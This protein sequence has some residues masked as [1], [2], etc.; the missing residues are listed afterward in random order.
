MLRQV[1]SRLVVAVSRSILPLRAASLRTRS[2]VPRVTSL[3]A[4]QFIRPFQTSVARFDVAP[5]PSMPDRNSLEEKA[6]VL[7]RKLDVNAPPEQYFD[8]LDELAS[9][10]DQLGDHARAASYVEK[11]L[12]VQK[13]KL[14]ET[15]IEVGDTCNK[16]ARLYRSMNE[17]QLA[18]PLQE[19]AVE[20]YVKHQGEGD[21][22]TLGT[23]I[24]LSETYAQAG[25][26]AGCLS[27]LNAA[28][29]GQRKVHGNQHMHL[30][31]LLD[32][33]GSITASI[34][35][36]AACTKAY[37]EA[38][39]ILHA[40]EGVQSLSAAG[41][42][43]NFGLAMTQSGDTKRGRELLDKALEVHKSAK[44]EGVHLAA[45]LSDAGMAL[46]HANDHQGALQRFKDALR[47]CRAHTPAQS[48]EIAQTA[49]LLGLQHLML[50]QFKEAA[51]L[52]SES[53]DIQRKLLGSRHGAVANTLVSLAGVYRSQK[54]LADA[55]PL[56]EEAVSIK[57]ELGDDPHLGV[58]LRVLSQAL[59]AEKQFD[60]ALSTIKEAEAVELKRVGPDS[61]NMSVVYSNM[62]AIYAATENWQE[63]LN[64]Y[65]K[66]EAIQRKAD[67]PMLIQTLSDVAGVYVWKQMHHEAL[68]YLEEALQRC[69]KA[70]VPNKDESLAQLMYNTAAVLTK[71]DTPDSNRRAQELYRAAHAIMPLP[72]AP[73]PQ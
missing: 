13:E 42:M 8:D 10:F 69:E 50:G 34:G 30:V 41:L 12:A 29:E 33:I 36:F 47:I 61:L 28:L 66:A 63:S 7:Q 73:Q 1:A 65:Q 49:G 24:T 70:E 44:G 52:Y 68:P 9:G 21:M 40:L 27:R 43:H 46:Q 39:N 59:H 26:F 32:R 53:L 55:V 15:S 5:L 25:D 38:V 58:T 54:K 4:R 57:R 51:S 3:A 22:V 72:G 45:M 48:Q 16:L 71:I 19:Q 20:I 62:G 67:H 64:N 6:K 37:D 18:I 35:D 14:G 31:Y 11:A 60:K 17:P 56:L 2:L 23:T